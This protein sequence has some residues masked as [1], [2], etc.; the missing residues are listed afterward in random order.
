MFKLKFLF[1]LTA[2]L[3]LL[4][5]CTP[6]SQ[7][8][9]ETKLSNET[10]PIGELVKQTDALFSQ[11]TDVAKLREAVSKI[12]QARNPEQRN[13]EVEWKFAKYSYF[14]S[15]Q[16]T[17]EKDA[18]KLLK[19]GYAAGMI[20][21]R[22]EPNKPDGYFWAGA[23][24]GEQSRRSPLTVGISSTDEIRGLMNKVIEIQPNYE[25]ASAFDVLA[26]IELST[27]LLGGSVEKAVQYLEKALQ[28]EKENLYIY[29][30]LAEAYLAVDKK[31]EAKKQID[32]IFKMKEDPEYSVEHKEVLERAKKMLE[33]K[34]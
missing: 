34:F 25:G 32:Y 22:L 3:F 14:L 24:L 23:C 16:T 18:E 27:R 29:L 11:R 31:T 4:T 2:S 21:S 7:A 10:I 1:L 12:A 8:D 30:H 33:T 9:S 15:K 17:D 19:D 13:F 6:H 20:A 28:I 5:S 26:Q